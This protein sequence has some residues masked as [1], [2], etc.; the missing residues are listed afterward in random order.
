MYRIEIHYIFFRRIAK[1][2]IQT[3]SEKQQFVSEI[4]LECVSYVNS[5]I[6]FSTSLPEAQVLVTF[7]PVVRRLDSARL[8]YAA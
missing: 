5:V 1:Q 8:R 6:E 4:F 3:T 2:V 7:K